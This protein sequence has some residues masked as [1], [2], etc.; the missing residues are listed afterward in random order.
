MAEPGIRR[1]DLVRT[2]GW[3]ACAVLIAD[4]VSKWALLEIVGLRTFPRVIEILPVFNLVMV[5]NRG[6]SFGLFAHDDPRAQWALSALAIAIVI[7]MVWWLQSVDRRLV[8]IGI[9]AVVGGAIGNVI[10]RLRF[11]AVADFFDAHIAGYHWP[12]FNIADSAIVIGVGLILIDGLFDG[13]N[14]VRANG[15][16]AEKAG[17]QTGEEVGEA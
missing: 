14:A 13:Q 16:A 17:G 8:A 6:V 3:L 12:A 9:G 11:G 1:P 2:A 10:D 15:M 5:W 7:G 4:Q